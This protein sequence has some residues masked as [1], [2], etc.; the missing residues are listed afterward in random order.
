MKILKESAAKILC[1]VPFLF[2]LI[3]D[4]VSTLINQAIFIVLNILKVVFKKL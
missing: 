1:D 2:F 4:D 3:Q